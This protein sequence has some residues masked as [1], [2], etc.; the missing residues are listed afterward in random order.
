MPNESERKPNDLLFVMIFSISPK[1]GSFPHKPVAL[2]LIT[3]RFFTKLI[4]RERARLTPNDLE[5]IR[6]APTGSKNDIISEVS[7]RFPV[8]DCMIRALRLLD[9]LV[10]IH[11]L[12]YDPFLVR[13]RTRRC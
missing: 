7:P 8:Y 2:G 6:G 1:N 3:N 11:E 12:N 4:P 5:E 9:P 13:A 10:S